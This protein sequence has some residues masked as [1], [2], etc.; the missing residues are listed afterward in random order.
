MKAKK[1]KDKVVKIDEKK[2]KIPKAIKLNINCIH[3]ANPNGGFV[4]QHTAI[5]GYGVCDQ[6]SSLHIHVGYW[7]ANVCLKCSSNLQKTHKTIE[8]G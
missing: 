5:C 1:S 6:P 7:C 3:T 2:I 8:I 4:S